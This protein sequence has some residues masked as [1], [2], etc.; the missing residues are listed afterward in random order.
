MGLI[1]GYLWWIGRKER[2][3]RQPGWA[4]IIAGFTLLFLGSV[5]DITDNFPSLNTYIIIGDTAYEAF[6]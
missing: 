5:L 6:P 4:Y 1:L 3:L 2:F